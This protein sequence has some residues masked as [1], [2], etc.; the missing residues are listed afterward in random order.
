MAPWSH[1]FLSPQG[2]RRMCCAS[3]EQHQF[4][5]QYIDVTHD[6]PVPD[7]PL[8]PEDFKPKT[9]EEH[10]NSPYM[11]DI[12]KRMMAGETLSQCEVCNTDEYNMNN[13]RKW[14]NILFKDRIQ[15]AFCNTDEDG[16]TTMPVRSFDYRVSNLCNFKCRMCGS[17]LSSSWEAE[18]R[19]EGRWNARW[20]PFMV[21]DIKRKM[22]QFQTEV[23]ENEFLNAVRSGVVEEIYWAGG[24]PLMYDIHWRVMQEMVDNGS[25]KKC[26]VRYNSNLS[27]TSYKGIELYDLLPHFKDWQLCASIDGTGKNVEYMRHGIVWQNWLNNFKR[28]LKLEN[29]HNNMI[30]DLTITGPGMF[31][32]KKL[33]DLAL[34]LD[35]KI[36]TKIVF[37]FHADK[38]V[39]PFAWP[40]HILHRHINDILRYITPRATYKQ[41]SLVDVLN[42]MLTQKTFEER[43]PDEY[44]IEFAKGK[45]NE[46]RLDALRNDS[47][48]LENIYSQDPELLKWWNKDGNGKT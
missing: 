22:Q 20:Q 12:R 29:G 24:E 27:R 15:E 13:Y 1:T 31:D 16:R 47:Y 17:Q 39:S 48:T 34:E 25:S 5:R 42:N 11:C 41:Q 2:E 36:E 10:W 30:I 37:A 44:L 33:F 14:F 45:E 7:N 26:V 18:D 23:A 4:Q 9:L 46:I 21:P 6:S 35:V 32:I 28:G 8:S 38:I 3:R 43:W 40:K 19:K